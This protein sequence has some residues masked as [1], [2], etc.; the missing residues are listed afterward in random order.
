MIKCFDYIC[1][2]GHQMEAFVEDHENVRCPLCGLLMGKSMSALKI[3]TVIVV[4]R[5]GA[6][7]AG[8]QHKFTR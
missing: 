8:N 5:P 6:V 2:C 3:F 4:G 7:N 1:D